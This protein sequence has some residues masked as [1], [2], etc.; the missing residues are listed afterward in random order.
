MAVI[1]GHYIARQCSLFKTTFRNFLFGISKPSSGEPS[2]D[3]NIRLNA[4]R[5]PNT[6]LNFRVQP[7]KTDVGGLE[8][9]TPLT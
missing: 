3:V 1:L 4:F 5:I 2:R 6:A 9:S 7:R 8:F